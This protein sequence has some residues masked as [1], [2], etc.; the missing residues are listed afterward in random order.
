M[1]LYF[2]KNQ[3]MLEQVFLE[4]EEKLRKSCEQC[5]SNTI[6]LSGGLDS[7]IIACILKEKKPTAI[8]VITKDFEGSDLIFCQIAAK[9]FDLPLTIFKADMPNILDAIKETISILKNFND[10][11]I[12]N[13][14]VTYMAIKWAK[15]QDIKS[16]ITG[17]GA[18]ELFAG[19]N[20]LLNKKDKELETEMKRISSIMHFPTQKIGESLGVNIESPFLNE[21]VK[22]MAHRL[23]PN[24]MVRMERGVKYGK[25]IL[26]KIFENK[27]PAEIT[28]RQKSPMQEGSGTGQLPSFFNEIIN[29]EEFVKKKNE[30]K[31]EFGVTIRTKESM[32]YFQIFHELYNLE[33]SPEN[34]TCCP[35]CLTTT[36]NSRFCRMC[37]A[38]PI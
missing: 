10:I 32:H 28:W 35:F 5:N 38:F 2:Q 11:E 16:V 37:G 3:S 22:E 31:K 24:L 20:F 23:P 21:K 26:R 30:I 27:I 8:S 4:L 14:I 25:W 6:A 9:K 29:D 1:L 34:Q 12:R 17:D 7:T 36:E 33:Q 19:Y 13:N 15:N 18:D